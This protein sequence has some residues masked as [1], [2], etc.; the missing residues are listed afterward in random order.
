MPSVVFTLIPIHNEE[1]IALSFAKKVLED[2]HRSNA[3]HYLLVLDSCTDLSERILKDCLGS[4]ERVH[5][6]LSKRS[7]GYGNAISEG[8]E[9]AKENFGC[10]WV[11][12][13]DCDLSNPIKEHDSFRDQI[14]N[15]FHVDSVVI[16]KGSRFLSSKPGLV[17][18]PLKRH[19]MSVTGNRIA[20]FILLNRFSSDPTNG[21]RAVRTSFR[22]NYNFHEP[23]FAS[24]VEEIYIA[25]SND[26][27]IWDIP[28]ELRY[29]L[30]L[31]KTS[32]FS[33]NFKTYFSYLKY[34][35]L[36]TLRLS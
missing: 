25:V 22:L 24:I 14:N 13:S 21:L 1:E 4:Q 18:L 17:G 30:A 3:A 5:I 34:I 8:I 32:S 27:E 31:R 12:I 6:I 11:I 35:F 9:F 19:V 26:F 2:L 33:F 7:K 20:R 10:E 29:D 15:I 28:S 36:S 23:S 16:I